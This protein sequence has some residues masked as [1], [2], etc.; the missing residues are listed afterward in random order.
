[1][2]TY[3]HQV[4]H[5]HIEATKNQSH[6]TSGSHAPDLLAVPVNFRPSESRRRYSEAVREWKDPNF[7]S[8][9]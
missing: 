2:E 5:L 6:H 8:F 7:V 9:L 3:T 1:M 4:F